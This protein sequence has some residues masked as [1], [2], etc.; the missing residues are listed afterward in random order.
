MLLAGPFSHT[1]TQ[2]IEFVKFFNI[3]PDLSTIYF[4]HFSE[5]LAS[6][7]YSYHSILECYMYN[8]F[9]GVKLSITYIVSF[10]FTTFANSS[11]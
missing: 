7:V 10:L 5:C 8:L 1:N 4:T 6:F 3:S 2:Y 9:S 11:F